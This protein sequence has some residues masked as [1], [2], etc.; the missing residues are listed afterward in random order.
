LT[1]IFVLLA[2]GIVIHFVIQFELCKVYLHLLLAILGKWDMKQ[3]KIKVDSYQYIYFWVD[4]R[5]TL[6]L[7]RKI[8]F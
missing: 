5:I 7:L 1:D 4:E 6:F 2:E 8:N 3:L